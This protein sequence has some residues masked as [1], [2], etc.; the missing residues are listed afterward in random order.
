TS[1]L[2]A[3]IRVSPQGQDGLQAFL[4]KRPPSWVHQPDTEEE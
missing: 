4:E 2:I 1:Q 3:D